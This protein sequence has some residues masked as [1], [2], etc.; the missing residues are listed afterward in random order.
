MLKNKV[1]QFIVIGPV[2]LFKDFLL[3]KGIA[4]I[5]LNIIAANITKP[6]FL[7]IQIFINRLAIFVNRNGLSTLC[8]AGL[9]EILNLKSIFA[10]QA[11]LYLLVKEVCPASGHREMLLFTSIMQPQ[12]RKVFFVRQIHAPIFK[13]SG[14][15]HPNFWRIFSQWQRAAWFGNWMGEL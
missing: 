15:D 3:I 7:L 13:M 1:F 2:R 11:Q 5:C 14:E 4:A 8:I 10:V 12:Q 6:A 9:K